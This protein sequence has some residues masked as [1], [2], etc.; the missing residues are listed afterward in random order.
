V[1]AIAAGLW[2]VLMPSAWRWARP[3]DVAAYEEGV[4]V[5]VAAAVAVGALLL[6]AGAPAPDILGLFGHQERLPATTPRGRVAGIVVAAALAIVAAAL[7]RS[8]GFTASS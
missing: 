4:A 2:L 7:V 3:G 6:A 8:S 5:A 1:P